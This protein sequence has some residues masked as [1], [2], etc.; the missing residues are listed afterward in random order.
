MI[1]YYEILKVPD[2]SSFETI[3]KNYKNLILES[4]PDKGGDS[5]KF[6]LILEAYELMKD[7]AKKKEYD[8]KLMY[9]Q[10]M[11]DRAE[12]INLN[13]NVYKFKCIQCEKENEIKK[14]SIKE[15][16]QLYQYITK[17]DGCS[18]IYKINYI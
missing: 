14:E 12:E 16:N 1:N 6:K 18:M 5:D 17:C 11:Y 10:E 2:F 13:K 4:H 7:E 3:K 15:Q 8:N 9:F